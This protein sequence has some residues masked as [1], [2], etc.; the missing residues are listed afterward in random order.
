MKKRSLLIVSLLIIIFATIFLFIN[1]NNNIVKKELTIDEVLE[2]ESYSKL[3]SNVKQFIKDYYEET[4]EILKTEDNAKQGE[5][6]LNP[7]YIDYLDDGDKEGYFVIPSITS[8]IPKISAGNENYP[9]KFDL[10]YVNGK[11][12]VTPNKDQGTE[13]LCWA[14]ATASLLETHDLIVK[15]KS[16][17][18][19]ATLFSEKQI[20]YAISSDGI[21]GG[22]KIFNY[23]RVLSSGGQ[24]SYASEGLIRKIIGVSDSWNEENENKINNN[25]QLAPNIVF[26]KANSSSNSLLLV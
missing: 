7:N 22:N 8:Y 5:A 19:S 11:N 14:Y 15:N 12:Y 23:N 24:L 10:R 2:T 13:G 25:S 6:F 17:D 3:S 20:D 4:G 18:G 26:N 21:I 9:S 16:Y 1:S